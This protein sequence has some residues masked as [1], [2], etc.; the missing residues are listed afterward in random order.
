MEFTLEELEII[1]EALTVSLNVGL[2]DLEDPEK[3]IRILAKRE[4]FALLDWKLFI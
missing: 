2:P 1:K 3:V 4:C